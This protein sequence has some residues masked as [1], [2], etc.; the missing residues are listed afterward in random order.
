MATA[1][2]PVISA[3]VS[4]GLSLPALVLHTA[5][6]WHGW[7]K[8]SPM[9]VLPVLEYAVSIPAFGPVVRAC[10]Y[11]LPYAGVGQKTSIAYSGIADTLP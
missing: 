1:L 2:Q 9:A 6:D 8:P 4:A 11:L 7:P 3:P 5:F 10:Q